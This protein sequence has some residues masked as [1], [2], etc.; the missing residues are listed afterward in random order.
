MMIL[1]WVT[2][3]VLICPF[4]ESCQLKRDIFETSQLKVQTFT[5]VN[6]FPGEIRFL[7]TMHLHIWP[8]CSSIPLPGLAI[9]Q[10]KAFTSHFRSDQ[11]G[12]AIRWTSREWLRRELK[13]S[14]ECWKDLSCL[15]WPGSP[16]NKAMEF[17]W[18]EGGG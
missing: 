18:G 10:P 16:G 2:L 3:V 17:I 4:F 14:I 1:M 8:H 13:S 11:K 12:S 6:G 7:H 5:S 9:L 15:P